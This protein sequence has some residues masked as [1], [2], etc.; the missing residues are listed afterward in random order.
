MSFS[1]LL[2]APADLPP[3]VKYEKLFK[4]LPKLKEHMPKTG[5][6][7]ISRNSL[8][9]A[10]IYKSLRRLPFLADLTFELNN[11]PSVSKALGFNPLTSAP[12]IERFSSFL[13]D[14]KNYELNLLHQQLVQELIKAGVISGK[15]IAID[16]CPIVVSLRENNLKTAMADRFNK[17]KKPAGNPDARLGIMIHYPIP[18]KQAIRYFW[19]YRNHVINDTVTELPIWETTKPA[20]VSE[21]SIAK[22]LIRDAIS[23]FNL[24][25]EVVA[26]DA[27]FDSEDFLRFII[28]ELGALAIIPHN[29]RGE[30][31]KGYQ[32]KGDKIICEAGLV[33]FR[34]GKMRP[35]KVGILYCQYSCPII[36]D[37]KIRYKYI[38]CPLFH[39]KF[40]NGKGCNVL[41]RLEPSIRSEI[42]YGTRKFKELYNKRSSVERI[43]SRLLA[44]AMQNPTVRGYNANCNHA[45]IAHIAV[46]LIALTAYRTGQQDKMRFV[47]SFVPNFL[48]EN[49]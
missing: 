44:I 16:S 46:L 1:E 26:G 3:A 2:F 31:S 39:Q 25:I 41:I 40:I 7:P 33:M 47:K 4:N 23:S 49:T 20:N 18:F 19:G 12:S 6:R 36:Y 32:I 13:H 37:K 17:T 10:L 27:N 8:L 11:N 28:K 30:Q 43:F 9:R 22:S 21:I 5:R 29:S 14:T 24:N 48:I 38:M 45:T 15:S 35:K 34:R 42:D